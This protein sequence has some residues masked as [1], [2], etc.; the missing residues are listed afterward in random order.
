MERVLRDKKVIAAFVLPAVLI[1]ALF[2]PLPLI[3]SLGL[4]FFRWDLLSPMKFA[5]IKNFIDLFTNDSIFIQ[6]LG[7]TFVYLLLSVLFQIP[8]AFVLAVM[9]TRGKRF[10]K[11]FRNIIFLPVT[12][13]G[14][15]VGLMFYFIYSPDGILNSIIRLFG[16]ANF[17]LAWLA[18]T[19]TAMLAV[20]VAVAWQYVG[21][22]MVIYITGITT[23]PNEVIEAAKIDGANMLQ[24]ILHVIFPFLKPIVQVSLVLITTSSLKAFDSIFVMTSGGPMHSTEVMAS[25]MYTKSFLQLQYGYGS[26]IGLIL[27]MLCVA[28]SIILSKLLRSDIE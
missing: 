18:D 2:I 3:E 12:F 17:Q 7:N 26:S 13:S 9:L 23:I 19:R 5:G 15:A 16:F 8:L 24:V 1:F 25:Y 22:H 4:S 14:A 27:F 20:C 10:E 6:A 28:F 21:Y 11:L